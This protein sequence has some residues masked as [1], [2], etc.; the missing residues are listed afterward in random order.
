MYYNFLLYQHNYNKDTHKLNMLGKVKWQGRMISKCCLVAVSKDWC[1]IGSRWVDQSSFCIM[2]SMLSRPPMMK[3]IRWRRNL[4]DIYLRNFHYINSNLMNRLCM[5][6]NQNKLNI[7]AC[8]FGR[9]L[10]IL[11]RN[12]LSHN[13][14]SN[15]YQ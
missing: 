5:K 6:L 9:H 2:R 7:I 10:L 1:R 11:A 3:L 8:I 4:K 15:I 12:T 14:I 13:L